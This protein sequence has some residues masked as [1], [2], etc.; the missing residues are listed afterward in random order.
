[1][2]AFGDESVRVGAGGL[3]YVLGAAVVIRDLDATRAELRALVPGRQERLHWRGEREARR[4]ALLATLNDAGVAVFASW[5]YPVARHRQERARRA[6]LITLAGDVARECV[7]ELVLEHR[8]EAGDRLDRQ[9]LLDAR[10]G[11]VADLRYRFA[12]PAEEPLLWA[13]DAIAG[14]MSVHLAGV[15]SVYFEAL[16]PS[17]L[18]VRRVED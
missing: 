15:T 1:V 5:S 13:A 17:V 16:R 3:L 12:R 7:D 6:C 14:A 8:D 18:V 2:I 11:G 10:H 9:T 4:L